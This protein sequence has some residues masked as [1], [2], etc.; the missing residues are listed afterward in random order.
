MREKFSGTDIFQIEYN[1][2]QRIKEEWVK[3]RNGNGRGKRDERAERTE[4]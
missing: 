3:I 2:K 1:T 4:Y